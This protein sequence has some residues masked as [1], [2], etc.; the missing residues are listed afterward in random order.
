MF[1]YFYLSP[2]SYDNIWFHQEIVI[3]S[4]LYFG[5]HSNNTDMQSN[6]FR[7]MRICCRH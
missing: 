3:E 5:V 6:L 4:P 7:K 2:S 1:D